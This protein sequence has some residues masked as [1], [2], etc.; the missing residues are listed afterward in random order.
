MKTLYKL[1]LAAVFVLIASGPLEADQPS[2][3]P[4]PV[5]HFDH[6]YQRLEK[7]FG[8]VPEGT[9][10]TKQQFEP[11]M[12]PEAVQYLNAFSVNKIDSQYSGTI[13]ITLDA[14][15]Q[16]RT[17]G[18]SAVEVEKTAICTYFPR[19]NGAIVLEDIKGI[20]VKKYWF[21]GWMEIRQVTVT[22]DTAGNT[23]ILVNLDTHIGP[24]SRTFVLR[25]DGT[26]TP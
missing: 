26:N 1:L 23:T 9:S 15:Y 10:L 19:P 16:G 25:P 3:P 4:L 12:G 24:I 7:I 6:A 21:L 14:P 8:A 5:Q 20:R 17:S 18:G 2:Q 13:T 11:A 22:T